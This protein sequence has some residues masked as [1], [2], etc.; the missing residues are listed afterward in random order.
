MH[1]KLLHTKLNATIKLNTTIIT[2]Y[3]K[4]C[5]PTPNRFFSVPPGRECKLGVISQE[6]LKIEVKLL[7]IA[8]RKSY[9]S[10]RLAQQQMTLS[11]FEW[12]FHASRAISAVAELLVINIRLLL[13]SKWTVTKVASWIRFFVLSVL[14]VISC[15]MSVEFICTKQCVKCS[16]CVC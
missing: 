16:P 3:T 9:M 10:R 13:C 8:N 5:P 11:D 14:N 7:L 6:G 15:W 1:I 12:P 4:A 2:P